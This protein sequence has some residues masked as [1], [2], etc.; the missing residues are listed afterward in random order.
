MDDGE[1]VRGGWGGV[2]GRR[3]YSHRQ[4]EGQGTPMEPEVRLLSFTLEQ[5]KMTPSLMIPSSLE[6]GCEAAYDKPLW[7][8]RDLV[9]NTAPTI[10][11]RTKS[12]NEKGRCLERLISTG[13]G[14]P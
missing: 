5:S 10:Q 1:E 2:E 6:P 4:Q 8:S 7:W 13:M 3:Y 14:P 12:E 9:A 11:K